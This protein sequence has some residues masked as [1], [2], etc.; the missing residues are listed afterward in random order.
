MIK[1]KITEMTL[2]PFNK[3][4]ETI[5]VSDRL[6]IDAHLLNYFEQRVTPKESK[7]VLVKKYNNAVRRFNS[8]K[9]KS[10]ILLTHPK[11]GV[12]LRIIINIYEEIGKEIGTLI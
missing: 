4:S 11:E 6:D 12:I 5:T 8:G 7:E 3:R 1:I 9:A 10:I 2:V